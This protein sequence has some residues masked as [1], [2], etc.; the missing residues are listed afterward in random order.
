MRRK[1]LVVADTPMKNLTIVEQIAA[2]T[3]ALT[4]NEFA[5]TMQIDYNTAYDM[6]RDGRLP[7]MKV[8]SSI[9]LDPAITAEWLRQRS[10]PAA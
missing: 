3:S 5:D 8:G 6:W 1:K 2:R 10:S 7:G 9:R 4:L